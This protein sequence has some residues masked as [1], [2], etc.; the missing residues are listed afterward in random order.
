MSVY[1]EACES[2]SMF[3]NGKLKDNLNIYATTAANPNESSWGTYCYPND[4]V[5]GKHMNT[6]LGD[7]YSVNWMENSDA[8]SMSGE[9]LAKQYAVVKQ[10]TTKSHVMQYGDMKFGSDPIG[11]FQSTLDTSMTEAMISGVAYTDEYAPNPERH[12]SVVDSRD[13]KLNHLYAR[14]MT[15]GSHKAQLDLSSEINHRMRTDDVFRQVRSTLNI[16]D[17]DMADVDVNNFDCYRQA[18]STYKHACADLDDY[19][20]K[21]MRVLAVACEKTELHGDAVGHAITHACSH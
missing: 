11:D 8:V 13:I 21:H 7:L 20:L 18:I 3:T 10:E 15:D 1:I 12:T 17:E 9:T 5:D 4:I 14:V 2:G 6:C 16:T 19:T